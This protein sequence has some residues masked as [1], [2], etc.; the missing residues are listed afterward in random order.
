MLIAN[1]YIASRLYDNLVLYRVYRAAG[2]TGL[3]DLTAGPDGCLGQCAPSGDSGRGNHP[4]AQHVTSRMFK[5]PL[6]F[7]YFCIIGAI[8][9]LLRMQ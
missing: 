7:Q 4:A 6:V 3:R 5:N 9:V 2:Y 8:S 1:G